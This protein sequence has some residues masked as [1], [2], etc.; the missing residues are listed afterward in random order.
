MIKCPSCSIEVG[1]DSHSCPSCGASLEDL[2]AP[3]RQLTNSQRGAAAHPA[4]KPGARTSRR[5]RQVSAHSSL[6]PD[7][8][9]DARFVPGTIFAE[10]YRIVGL[11][12]RGGM[13]E[14]YRADDLK[15]GQPVALKFLPE[16]LLDD[17]AALARFH[18][19]VRTARQITH[20]NVCRVYD[21]GEVEREHFLSMEFVRGEDLASLLRRIGRLPSDK[22]V[23]IARQL[24]AGLAAAHDI[25][26]LHRDLKPANIMIDALGNVR[27]MDFG[28][29]GLEEELREA[30][31]IEGTPE[32]MSP[33]QLEG[34]ELT[35][36]SDIYSLGLVLY[37][38]FTGKKAFEA[39]SL[40]ELLRLRKSGAPPS[41]PS[42]LNK[43]IDPLVERIIER[44][45]EREPEK[46]PASAIQV[47][48]A[49]PG[50]DPLAAAL[51]A[52]ET[53]SPE[54][55]AAAK[56]EG[57]LR[58]QIAVACLASILLGLALIV[59]LS[60]RVKLNSYA[61]L[62]K[63]PDVLKE[64]A[65]EVLRHAGYVNPPTDSA[66]ELSFDADYLRYI[67]DNDKS[68]SRWE[69]LK[70]GHPSAIY[71][72]YR[73]SP[74]YLV[75]YGLGQVT[76]GDPPQIITDMA[77]VGLDTDGRLII[78]SAVPPQYDESRTTGEAQP[79]DWSIL[80]N[81]ARLDMASFKPTESKW[82]PPTYADSMV[83]WEGTLPNQPQI[84][85]RV[86]GAS[87]RGRPVLF[88]VIYP[89]DVPFRQQEMQVG[90]TERII[91]SVLFTFLGVVIV[92]AVLLAWR[93]LRSGRGDRRG[94]TRLALFIFVV[95][96][97]LWVVR[98]H[99]VPTME[100][101][102]NLF[103]EGL[104]IAVF[105][106]S[107]FWVIYIALE[108]FVRRHWP[109][110]IISWTRLLAGDLRDPLVGRDVLIGAMLGV[111]LTLVYNLWW[112]A[113]GWAGLPG[114][115]PTRIH[116]NALLGPR[117]FLTYFTDQWMNSLLQAIC[118][119]FV[120][121]LLTIILRRHRLA[122]G[123]GWLMLAA[124][125]A[126]IG[127][128]RS[129]GLLFNVMNLLFALV[130][131][132]IT[133]TALA[134]FG[135]LTTAFLF[136]FSN[137]TWL[138]PLTSDFSAWYAWSTLFILVTLAGLAVYGFITSLAGQKLSIGN[139]LQD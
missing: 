3:T 13:G 11:L 96:V 32:Y 52:G 82:L 14:V 69:R 102:F 74:R 4:A 87:Y 120:L 112:L 73:Q 33:E 76:G 129:D 58:P 81:E 92:S 115:V 137:L 41:T 125:M 138:L 12:G 126:L 109:N 62:Q 25:G 123:A 8:A 64:R 131:T 60:G 16:N 19:E 2:F 7:F 39:S 97:I 134:R 30:R 130:A 79:F 57:T 67:R 21:I 119:M 38:I 132:T 89:W 101:E 80:F 106:V 121:L 133:I 54:M 70:S 113:P 42:S 1:E 27:I 44:C 36:Q 15:L 88:E 49:L 83:A 103:M 26:V 45:L 91:N 29:A 127:S 136:L 43:H 31:A 20:R 104:A 61:P 37:E 51:A 98:T 85:I 93:N 65:K 66:Y 110:R 86:A 24:C 56:K 124:V 34:K 53:P 48:A 117:E 47:A 77:R 63:T 118:Y 75:P 99:H 107:L 22:A 135:L 111:S 46:R 94:A 108:P 139:L 116:V 23:E 40:N 59:F 6:T 9:E 114:Y 128:S 55:V 95:N 28:L 35:A 50:G 105:L 10:R 68:P 100:G 18:R 78:F 84:P 5:T 72:W 71:F 90:L 17:G 122:I